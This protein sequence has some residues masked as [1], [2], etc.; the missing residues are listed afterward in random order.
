MGSGRK[1]VILGA[2]AVGI[3]IFVLFAGF[4]TMPRATAP[5]LRPLA[6]VLGTALVVVGGLL[7]VRAQRAA[8]DGKPPELKEIASSAAAS[9]RGSRGPA[10]PS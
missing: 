2:V 3:G 9:N 6:G 7:I 10:A 5:P 1:G 4:R 8:V